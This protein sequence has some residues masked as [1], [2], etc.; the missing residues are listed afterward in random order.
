VVAQSMLRFGENSEVTHGYLKLVD[1]LLWSVKLPDHPQS[2]QRLVALLPG[3][4]KRL[5]DGM[6]LIGLPAA[7]Q[8]GVLDELMAIHTEALRPGRGDP[9]DLTSEQIVQRM[10]S[11]VLPASTGHGAFSDS[12]IDLAS[13]QTVPA[14]LMATPD[15]RGSPPK[16]VD[17]LLESDRLRLFLRGRWARVQ[18]LWR[19]EQHLFFL[20]AGETPARTYSV[21]HRALERLSSAGLM[22]PLENRSLIQRALDTVT[23]ELVRPS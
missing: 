15:A 11:E 22:Q 13:M 20:F 23:R 1:E 3:M 10:R 9:K 17:A 6:E 16:G 21:T 14:E 4:L 5:R 12:V 8:D 19:S 7:E 2:R 18:L